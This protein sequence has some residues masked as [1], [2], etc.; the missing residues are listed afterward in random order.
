[1]IKSFLL[2][3]EF[4]KHFLAFSYLILYQS[5]IKKKKYWLHYTTKGIFINFH[6]IKNLDIFINNYKSFTKYYLP[7]K[8]DII[9]DLGAGLGQE[10]FYFSKRVGVKGKVITFEPDPRLFDVIKK[11]IFLNK[12]NNVELYDKAFFSKNNKLIKFNLVENWMQN[13]INNNNDSSKFI[14]IRTVTLDHIIKKNKIKKIDFAKFNIEGA[15][16]FLQK[17]NKNFLKICKNVGISCHDFINGKE[18][19]TFNNV[20][21]ILVKNNFEIIDNNSSDKIFKYYVYAK[22]KSKELL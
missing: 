17:G 3:N 22:K 16:K 19:K 13:S 21:K 9:F 18:F 14:K 5:K 12:L 15:E 7:K 20:K 1:M 8:N 4:I 10:T 2:K 6:P 11:M